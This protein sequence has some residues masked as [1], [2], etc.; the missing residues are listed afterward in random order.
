[1]NCPH[2][3][4]TLEPEQN[5]GQFCPACLSKFKRAVLED[6]EDQEAIEK[7][8]DALTKEK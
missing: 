7:I 1:M 8:V 3:G 2:C 5:E 4:R 6:Q